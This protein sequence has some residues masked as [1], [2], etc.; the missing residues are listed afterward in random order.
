MYYLIILKNMNSPPTN[1]FSHQSQQKPQESGV[2][3]AL[4]SSRPLAIESKLSPKNPEPPLS[5]SR[6]FPSP[7]SEA[8]SPPFLALFRPEKNWMK[9]FFFR[10]KSESVVFRD[11][12]LQIRAS[13]QYVKEF[14][15]YEVPKVPKVFGDF[16]VAGGHGRGILK[17]SSTYF[18]HF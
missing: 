11:Y 3:K 5:S 2:K 8:M 18:N 7:F 13:P 6:G 10:L 14:P 15:P 4:T 16:T 12:S 9:Y 1:F 17:T